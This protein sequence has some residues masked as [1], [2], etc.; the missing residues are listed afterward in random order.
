LVIAFQASVTKL[1]PLYAIGVFL[2]FTLSQT[3]MAVRWWK[4]GH[5]KPGVI[6]T[7]PG[8]TLKFEKGWQ[9]K[10]VINGFGA[11]CTFVVMFVFAITKFAEGAWVVVILIPV[12]IS[13]F[14]AIHRHYKFLANK[15]SLDNRF[16]NPRISRN[17]VIIPIGGVHQGTLAALQYAKTLSDDVTALHVSVDE[18]ETKKLTD[19]WEMWGDNC[20]LVIIKSAYRTFHQ[21]LLEYVQ[22]IS[23][24]CEP[25]EMITIVIPQFI[26]NRI[27]ERLLH[28]RTAELIRSVLIGQKNVVIIEVPYQIH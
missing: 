13:I 10:L 24:I 21:P 17:R 22:E 5:L 11:I 4:I 15:L 25:S 20:R 26:T 2:S 14:F 3:G 9:T 7:E 18:K 12:L 6:I 1:I 19:K 27:W 28:S 16:P 23:A 8:S